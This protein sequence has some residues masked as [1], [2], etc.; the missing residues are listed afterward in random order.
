M[1]IDPQLLEILACPE[2]KEDVK[3]TADDKGLKC[4]KCHRVY[5]IKDDIPVML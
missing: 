1:A 3:L 4:V 5:P 2:C